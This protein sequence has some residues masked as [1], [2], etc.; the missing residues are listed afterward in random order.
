MTINYLLSVEMNWGNLQGHLEHTLKKMVQERQ[1]K[2][3]DT[4]K[5]DDSIKS[6]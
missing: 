5:M 1:F 3:E 4:L 2:T 6:T